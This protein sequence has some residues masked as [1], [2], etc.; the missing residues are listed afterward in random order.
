MGGSKDTRITSFGFRGTAISADFLVDIE[1][2]RNADQIDRLDE[3]RA[4]V[5]GALGGHVSRGIVKNQ[6]LQFFGHSLGGFIAEGVGLD[7]AGARIGTIQSGAPV[8]SDS[9]RKRP[10]CIDNMGKGLI[11]SRKKVDV[12]KSEL[13][14]TIAGWGDWASGIS[15][16]VHDLTSRIA[17][18][19]LGNYMPWYE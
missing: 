7:Y 16:R 1:L 3:A 10:A 6:Y 12:E 18:H 11:V 13:A 15:N 2:A 5:R 8:T 17:Q 14:K 4:F 9:N 19:A